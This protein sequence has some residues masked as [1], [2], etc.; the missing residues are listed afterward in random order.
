M[1]KIKD[2]FKKLTLIFWTTYLW[3]CSTILYHLSIN[4]IILSTSKKLF[5]VLLQF[6]QKLKCFY[7]KNY[8]RTEKMVNF[9]DEWELLIQAIFVL[10]SKKHGVYHYY[11]DRILFFIDSRFFSLITA[12]IW[13]HWELL[14]MRPN[15]VSSS[16]CTMD[17]IIL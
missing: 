14:P 8:V 4:F 9:A 10:P 16:G 2:I 7:E 11:P 17:S 5:Q 13:S 1:N 6:S 3:L 15:E 12:F